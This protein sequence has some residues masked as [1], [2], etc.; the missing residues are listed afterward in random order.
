MI[1]IA[2]VRCSYQLGHW[3]SG[4]GAE[5]GWYTLGWRQIQTRGCTTCAQPFLFHWLDSAAIQ[6]WHTGSG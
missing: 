1:S 5:G 2:L 3:S 4:I 6:T